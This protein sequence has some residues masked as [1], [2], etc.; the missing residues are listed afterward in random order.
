VLTNRVLLARLDLSNTAQSKHPSHCAPP[1]TLKYI[2]ALLLKH[3]LFDVKLLDAMPEKLSNKDIIEQAIAWKPKIIVLSVKIVTLKESRRFI[4]QI[5]KKQNVFI[6][7][8]GSI[9]PESISEEL[10]VFLPGFNTKK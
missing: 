6:V 9:M 7:V 5:R 2:E 3:K 8:V 1:Y 4:S 10:D